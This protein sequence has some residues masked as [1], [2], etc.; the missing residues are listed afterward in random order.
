MILLRF[1]TVERPGMASGMLKS[2]TESN[3]SAP[4]GLRWK[5][6]NPEKESIRF[7]DKVVGFP[8]CQSGN[9]Q[10]PKNFIRNFQNADE[11]S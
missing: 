10:D 7:C 1:G 6:V 5:Y 4:V 3:E 9:Y 2:L 11:F 8:E